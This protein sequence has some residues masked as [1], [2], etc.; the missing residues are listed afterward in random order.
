MNGAHLQTPALR[1][2]ENFIYNWQYV[3]KASGSE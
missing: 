1:E 3:N 2:P